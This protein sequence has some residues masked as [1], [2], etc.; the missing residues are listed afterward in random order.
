MKPSTGGSS[1]PG[2]V[3]LASM[4]EVSSPRETPSTVAKMTKDIVAFCR[5][6]GLAGH[7]GQ[8]DHHKQG[9]RPKGERNHDNANSD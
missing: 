3:W 6:L 1:V 5:A 7:A 2:G 9:S 4:M 8:K